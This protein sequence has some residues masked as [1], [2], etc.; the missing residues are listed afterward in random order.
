MRLHSSLAAPH[1][2]ARPHPVTEATTRRREA[3][4]P[5]WRGEGALK[6]ATDQP[7][8]RAQQSSLPRFPPPNFQRSLSRA[9]PWRSAWPPP[10]SPPPRRPR[11]LAAQRSLLPLSRP[12]APPARGC[13]Y[14][15]ASPSSRRFA[16][17]FR[18]RARAGRYEFVGLHSLTDLVVVVGLRVRR[19][20]PGAGVACGWSG[21][22][23]RR[24]R[25]SSRPRGRTSRSSLRPH[26]AIPSWYT[27]SFHF[28]GFRSF[29]TIT[30]KERTCIFELR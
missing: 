15:S 24:A 2:R 8:R 13:A 18:A 9:A 10:S 12:R 25:R 30:A 11:P 5:R 20:P 23:R 22:W 17:N 7:R 14:A 28:H 19:R 1:T 6:L 16:F 29:W 3:P 21:A 26:T 4:R 27:T